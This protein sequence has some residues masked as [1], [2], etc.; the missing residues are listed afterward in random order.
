MMIRRFVLGAAAAAL[1]ASPV[2]AQSA[3]PQN[4]QP[5]GPARAQQPAPQPQAPARATQPTQAQPAQAPARATAPAAATQ[6]APVGKRININTATA[7]ELDQ[8]KGIG[9]ARAAKIIEERQKQRFRNFD[10]LVQRNVLPSNVEA[11][12]RNQISF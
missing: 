12:I 3:Q 5:S 9:P 1:I 4:Q 2:L 6:Q 10:D 8:L 11:D 7:A